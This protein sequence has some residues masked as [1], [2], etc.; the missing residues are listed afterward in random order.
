MSG[1]VIV[2]ERE[3]W[4]AG[5]R[6]GGVREERVRQICKQRPHG[7]LQRACWRSG[8]VEKLRECAIEG[9][10]GVKS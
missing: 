9:E 6:R 1:L 10:C 3:R 8:E 4:G 5:G 2:G 7:E